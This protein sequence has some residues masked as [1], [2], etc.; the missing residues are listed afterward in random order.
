MASLSRLTSTRMRRSAPFAS[1]TILHSST[2]QDAAISPFA[3]NALFRS[4]AQIPI[5]QS[6]TMIPRIRRRL[7]SS[8]RVMKKS[9]SFLSLRHVLSVSP[10]SLASLTSPLHSGEGWSTLAQPL[11][12]HSTWPLLQ[13]L[14]LLL[15][16][17]GSLDEELRRY[18]QVT[19]PS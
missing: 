13:C 2:K 12:I 7:R 16:H 10:Q 18:Q 3:P 1:Y 14:L 17:L 8:P 4:N 6:I 19:M 15:W 5:H 9:C 11:C